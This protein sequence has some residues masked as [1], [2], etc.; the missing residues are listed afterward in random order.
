MYFILVILDQLSLNI[1][2]NF[3]LSFLLFVFRFSYFISLK[4]WGMMTRHEQIYHIVEILFAPFLC[5]ADNLAPLTLH[6]IPKTT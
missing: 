6:L 4:Y 5:L 2:A 1:F 3:T